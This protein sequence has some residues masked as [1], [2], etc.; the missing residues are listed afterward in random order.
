MQPLNSE[1]RVRM[2]WAKVVHSNTKLSR[3]CVFAAKSNKTANQHTGHSSLGISRQYHLL[4]F[5]RKRSSP[6]LIQNMEE[7]SSG[8]WTCGILAAL[9]IRKL[10]GSLRQ[11]TAKFRHKHWLPIHETQHQTLPISAQYWF[12]FQIHFILNFASQ[13]RWF[14][15]KKK[16]STLRQR[17]GRAPQPS[18]TF[19]CQAGVGWWWGGGGPSWQRRHV[20]DCMRPIRLTVALGLKT[21]SFHGNT[22]CCLQWGWIWENAFYFQSGKNLPVFHTWIA[23]NCLCHTGVCV[24]VGVCY[25]KHFN[26]CVVRLHWTVCTSWGEEGF[27]LR[28]DRH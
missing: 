13:F 27:S 14:P 22:N 24:C 28:M 12:L 16:T 3:S 2:F 8:P 23:Q 5:P 20:H 1:T 17:K 11:L 15:V 25:L 4:K 10:S 26:F 7:N 9:P 18:S 21:N 19:S 6:H